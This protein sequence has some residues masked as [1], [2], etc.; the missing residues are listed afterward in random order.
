MHYIENK[1]KQELKQITIRVCE[2][3]F[4]IA[5]QKKQFGNE[6]EYADG[7]S[8]LANLYAVFFNDYISF[9]TFFELELEQQFLFELKE[10]DDEVSYCKEVVHD[11]YHLYQLV[12][13]FN[14]NAS[15]N[16]IGLEVQSLLFKD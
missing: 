14:P 10:N 8:W 11:L 2:G 6:R 7:S 3:W 9:D 5:E 12:G 13:S 15:Y 1:R 4:N 16:K